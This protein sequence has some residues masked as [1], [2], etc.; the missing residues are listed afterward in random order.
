MSKI[1][2]DT[3]VKRQENIPWKVIE[4]EGILLN[5]RN[6]NY[7]TINEAGLFIWKLL[8]G[9]KNLEKIA[10]RISSRYNIN[11]TLAFSD[12][13]KFIKTLHIKRLLVICE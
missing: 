8:D 12:L 1:T 11:K 5:L 9:S 10:K 3:F 7:F 4:N 2:A 6:G 13:L